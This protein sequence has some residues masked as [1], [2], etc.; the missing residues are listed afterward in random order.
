MGEWVKYNQ[1]FIPFWVTH[2]QVTESDGFSRLLAQTT[3]V[4]V[5]FRGLVD[6]A[7]HL[8]DHIT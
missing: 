1:L 8:Y 2:L 5:P 4:G 7:A 6:I 3:R